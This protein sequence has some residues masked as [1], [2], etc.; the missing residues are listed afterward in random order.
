MQYSTGS[1]PI[2]AA[3]F[4]TTTSHWFPVA[5]PDATGVSRVSKA[6]LEES[7]AYTKASVAQGAASNKKCPWTYKSGA[8]KYP[9]LQ[10]CS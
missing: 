7:M 6:V 2:S 3:I 4:Q 8:F 1:Q 9:H 10:N 5:A